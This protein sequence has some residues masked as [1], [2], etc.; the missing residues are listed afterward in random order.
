MRRWCVKHREGWC[1]VK[2]NRRFAEDAD[3]VPTLCGHFVIFPGGI[4]RGE[5]DCPECLTKLGKKQGS[6]SV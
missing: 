4:K 3:S 1:A 6:T 2:G 5:P